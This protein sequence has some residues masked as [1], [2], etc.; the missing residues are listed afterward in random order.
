MKFL[1]VLTLI[2][3]ASGPLFSQ[4]IVNRIKSHVISSPE[5][6]DS[7][8]VEV[9]LPD[10]YS[11][12]TDEYPVCYV[13]DGQWFFSHAMSAE[14]AFTERNG[15]KK[16]P[17]FI[18]VGISLNNAQRFNWSGETSK[19]LMFLSQ[20]LVP[21]IDGNYRTNDER[22]L[23]GWEATGGFVIRSLFKENSPFS[24]FIAASPSPLYGE[25]FPHLK[26]EFTE[27]EKYLIHAKTKNRYVFIAEAENDYP[28]GYGIKNILQLLNQKAPE[29]WRWSF[30][31]MTGVTHR[32]TAYDA[33]FKGIYQYFQYYERL[34]YNSLGSFEQLGG[35]Q[36]LN[37]YYRKRSAKYQISEEE[38]IKSIN[39]TKRGLILLA[40]LENNAAVFDTFYVSFGG[41]KFIDT[42]FLPHGIAVGNYCLNHQNKERAIEIFQ[43][44]INKFPK[45]ANAYN[46]LAACFEAN[47]N[48]EEAKTYYQKAV[49]L[50]TQNDNYRLITYQENLKRVNSSN[51]DY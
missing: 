13:L 12:S 19:L 24:G 29:N 36:Y 10:N 11:Q 47:G 20:K 5:L 3:L 23:F 9:F 22:I 28:S 34:R 38:T 39:A 46:G 43:F 2:F 37:G 33:I 48:V 21:F 8:N 7:I 17:Y 41:L 32:M 35:I 27:F 6:A 16:T 51:N 30:Q 26:N 49:E 25:Y 18:V 15:G 50:A 42:L 45:R 4:G 31:K 40:I 1:T 14:M 44:L